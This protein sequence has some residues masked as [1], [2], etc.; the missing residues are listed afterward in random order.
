MDILEI[1][2]AV[3]AAFGLYSILDMLRTYI[4]FPSH[5]RK[6]VRAAVVYDENTYSKAV[7]YVNYLKRE[8]KISPERLIILEKND[9]INFEEPSVICT[10]DDEERK[11]SINDAGNENTAKGA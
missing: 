5:I 8:Q 4:V 10:A 11:E 3:L 9:I 2:V 1:S 7:S 6:A